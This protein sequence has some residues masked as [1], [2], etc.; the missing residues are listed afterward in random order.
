MLPEAVACL[1]PCDFLK[2]IAEANGLGNVRFAAHEAMLFGTRKSWW[3][4]G[5]PRPLPHEGVDLCRYY[6]DGGEPRTLEPG[7]RIP[8]AFDGQ[9]WEVSGDDFIGTS[10]FIRHEGPRGAFFTAYA[11]VTPRKGLA[12]G[13]RLGRGEVLAVLVDPVQRGLRIAC[14]LHLSLMTFS[15]GFSRKA[16]RWATMGAEDAVCFHDP[17]PLLGEELILCREAADASCWK[18]G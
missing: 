1:P 7:S 5:R 3:G 18:R 2:G 17:A 6:T 10:L 15:D 4:S 14:H 9:V 12:R 8:A 16:L 11:H 13:D